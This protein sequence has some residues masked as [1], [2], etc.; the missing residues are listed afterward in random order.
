[1]LTTLLADHRHFHSDWQID[2]AI[3]AKAGG[4]LYGCYKQAVREL[5]KRWRGL[6]ECYAKRERLT[7]DIDDLEHLPAATGNDA[8]RRGI[9][10]AEKR[11]AL[12]EAAGV[13]RDT[14]REFVRFVGQAIACR[15]ALGVADGEQLPDDRREQLDR[16]M[17]E[18]HIRSMAAADYMTIG[19]L[20]RGTVELLAATDVEMR[21]RLAQDVLRP[22]AHS[23]LIH[24]YLTHDVPMPEPIRLTAEDEREALEW[25]SRLSLPHLPSGLPAV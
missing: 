7:L 1:M 15:R 13:I 17:W 22:E 4:T 24:W 10:I 21:Q 9:Y 6:R 18:H 16:E 25:V 12:I 20:G 23:A 8:T 19:R 5:H 11:L 2:Y 14:E 3:T